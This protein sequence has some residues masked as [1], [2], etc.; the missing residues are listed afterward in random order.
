MLNAQANRQPLSS[1]EGEEE[2]EEVMEG[3]ARGEKTKK[4][5]KRKKRSTGRSFKDWFRRKRS[6]SPPIIRKNPYSRAVM[7]DS[8]RERVLF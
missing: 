2:E 3:E 5:K 4:R 8:E 1:I 7:F 6:G